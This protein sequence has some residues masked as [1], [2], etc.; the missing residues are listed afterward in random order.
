MP[1]AVRMMVSQGQVW[2]V[3]SSQRPRKNPMAMATGKRKPRDA[4][5]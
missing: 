2:K 4:A 1:Q 3:R 5:W